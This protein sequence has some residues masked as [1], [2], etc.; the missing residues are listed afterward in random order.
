MDRARDLYSPPPGRRVPAHNLHLTL[1]FL[2]NVPAEQVAEVEAA[3]SAVR[4]PAFELVLDRFGW[5]PAARVL[6]L[7]GAAP[8]AGVRLVDALDEALAPLALGYDRRAWVPHVTVFRKVTDG[9]RR[10]QF[11]PL[12]WRVRRFVLVES[13]P[14]APYQ[15][16]R[17]WSLQLEP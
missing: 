4:A 7:G 10:P 3:A 11:T 17:S 15:L 6:W 14:G 13:L 2:G 16:L 1:R 5:F 8:E 12:H 9:R